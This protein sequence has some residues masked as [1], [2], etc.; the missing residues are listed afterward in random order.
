M[1]IHS[2]FETAQGEPSVAR[3]PSK[4]APVALVTG[5]TSGFGAAIARRLAAGGYRIIAVGRREKRLA[6]LAESLGP[7]CL[8]L[9]VDVGD[10]RAVAAAIGTLPDA[11]RKIA[12]LVNNAGVALGDARAQDSRLEDWERT[13]RTNV[14]GLVN[15][16]HAVLPLMLAEGRGDIVTMGSIAG[17]LPYPKGN[18]YGATKAFA[19]QFTLN[20]RADLLGTDI[21]AI[22]IEP[23]TARTEFAEVRLGSRKAAA[24]FYDRE[25]LL[26]ADDVA[27]IVEFCIALPRRVNVNVLEVMPTVQAFAFPA[28]AETAPGA[29]TKKGRSRR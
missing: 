23:G 10:S 6:A 3:N 28:F 26:E 27:A 13:I 8:P 25:G 9:A 1:Y 20:L 2:D 19:H 21:R 14:D 12:V 5:A 24:A 11:F 29:A 16:T 15:M 7:R 4:A 22:C 18:V 17:S